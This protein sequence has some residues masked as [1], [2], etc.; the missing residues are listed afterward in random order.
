MFYEGRDSFCSELIAV[1]CISALHFTEI[2]TA[3]ASS[4]EFFI[5]CLSVLYSDLQFF[6][7]IHLISIF[8]LI[9]YISNNYVLLPV[10][11]YR[12]YLIFHYLKVEFKVEV[13]R[14]SQL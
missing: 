12:T 4:V 3:V 10:I 1:L 5:L 11:K 6:P 2:T 14:V 13:C 8:N 7:P 9:F